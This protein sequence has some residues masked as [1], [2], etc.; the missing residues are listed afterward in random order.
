MSGYYLI[1]EL[2]AIK[3]HMSNE[4]GN[5]FDSDNEYG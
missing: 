5:A 4:I 3:N 2:K 1:K